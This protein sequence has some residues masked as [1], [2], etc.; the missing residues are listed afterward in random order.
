MPTTS[1]FDEVLEQVEE[2]SP[3]DQEALID[4]I[5]KR[6]V[7]RRRSEIADN[8]NQS[9]QEYRAGQVRLSGVDDIMAEL[10]R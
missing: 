8:I 10:S 5:R 9:H 1:K 6:L 2:L 3:P 4:L 7:E